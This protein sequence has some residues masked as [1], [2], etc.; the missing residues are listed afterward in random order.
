MAEILEPAGPVFFRFGQ[1]DAPCV[2]VIAGKKKEKNT[3][4]LSH[5]NVRKLNYLHFLSIGERC[6]RN[7]SDELVVSNSDSSEIVSGLV[8]I[9][10]AVV[11]GGSVG[12]VGSTRGSSLVANL[13]VTMLSIRTKM[14]LIHC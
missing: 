11:D 6:C 14:Q 12:V 4:S 2:S 1:V 9:V 13:P 3:F 5:Q 10:A 8:N 7:I